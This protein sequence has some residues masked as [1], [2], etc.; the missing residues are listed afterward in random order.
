[1]YCATKA[2]V[3]SFTVSLRYQLREGTVRVIEIIPPAVQSDLHS[4]MG[5]EG[6]K[7][8]MLSWSDRSPLRLVSSDCCSYQ[9][10]QF[11]RR[12]RVDPMSVTTCHSRSQK[13]V[14]LL[15]TPMSDDNAGTK[16]R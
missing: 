2:A 15:P 16:E 7:V 12:A 5:P 9:I 10:A 1:M 4:F 13:V 6:A 3:R 11:D 8:S 14:I